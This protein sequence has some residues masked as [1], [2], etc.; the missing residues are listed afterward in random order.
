MTRRARTLSC[1][2][3]FDQF[4]W[5]ALEAFKECTSR[6]SLYLRLL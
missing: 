6:C 3:L 4:G 5:N 1:Y 2:F